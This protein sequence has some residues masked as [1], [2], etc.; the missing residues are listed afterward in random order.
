[1]KKLKFASMAMATV[2]AL[3]L[4]GCGADASH[5][6]E[7]TPSSSE[8][9]STDAASAKEAGAGTLTVGFDQDFPPMGYKDDNGD[10]VGFDLDLAAETAKRLGLEIVYQPIAWDSKDAELDAGTIDCI[11]NGFTMNGRE[12][13]YEWSVPYLDNTQVFVVAEDSGINS[14][15]D[16]AGK[17]IEVQA[18]SSAEAALKEEENAE[19]AASFG[20]LQ[21]TPDYNTAL[22]DLD[23]GAV[24]AVAM[25]STVADYKITS[26]GLK[27]K[28]LD[29]A[30]ASEEYG[31]GFKKGNTELRDKV[32]NALQEMAE[33]GTMAKIS[34]KWF[35]EDI[36]TVGK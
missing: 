10:F 35:G 2:M 1:M 15:A 3:T 36:T 20:T 27:L 25:D 17:T 5:N 31:I 32:N 13:D 7:G 34:E 30:F 29:D 18:D 12:D 14:A 11:W 4:A 24:D 19:L 21:T 22:M 16:L 6:A 33:D 26:G 23:M 28:V 9:S 8:S